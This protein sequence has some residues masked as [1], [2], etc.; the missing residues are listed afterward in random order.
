ML[1]RVLKDRRGEAYWTGSPCAP[2]GPWAGWNIYALGICI[3]FLRLF[4]VAIH[5]YQKIDCDDLKGLLVNCWDDGNAILILLKIIL[6]HNFQ[7]NFK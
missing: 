3:G 2:Y 4:I 7:K 6:V 5:I 1:I